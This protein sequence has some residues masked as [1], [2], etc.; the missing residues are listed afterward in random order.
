MHSLRK[1][2]V[3]AGARQKVLTKRM[4]NNVTIAIR[5]VIRHIQNPI[6]DPV[7]ALHVNFSYSKLVQPTTFAVRTAVR[8]IQPKF[9]SNAAACILKR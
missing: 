3:R 7:T 9:P 8:L 4:H 1:M 5:Y 6:L 2:C